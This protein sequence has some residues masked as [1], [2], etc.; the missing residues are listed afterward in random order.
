V[1]AGIQF[2]HWGCKGTLIIDART[3]THHAPPLMKDAKVESA[4]DRFFN[5]GASLYQKIK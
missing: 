3:K 5:K 2:K 1:E 4:I